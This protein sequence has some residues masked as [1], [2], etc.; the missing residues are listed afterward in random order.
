MNNPYLSA[1]QVR[2]A[3]RRLHL[4]PTRGMG[5]HFLISAGTLRRIV[6]AAALQPGERVIEVGPGLGVLTWELLQR[7]AHVVAVELDK[8]LAAHLRENLLP[9]A[10]AAQQ[11]DTATPPSAP[12]HI[13]QGDV[14]RL[15]PATLLQ[16]A[17]PHHPDHPAHPPDYKVVANLPYAITS[18][19]LRHFLEHTPQPQQMVVLVQWEV[20]QRITAAPGD[21]SMLAHAIQFYAQ[22]EIVGRVAAGSFVPPPAVASAI[23]RLWVRPTPAVQVDDTATFFALIKAGFSQPR[24]KL[25]NALAGGLKAQGQHHIGREQVGAALHAAGVAP[26][27]RAET[28]ALAEWAAIYRALA[29]RS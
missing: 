4:Q 5:Q 29:Q 21:L 8:R 11:H 1:Q 14:L 13:V 27:R 22:P 17:A 12:L 15:P 26:E 20:A 16:Q 7:G 28:V 3:L 19:V 6:E 23:L 25:A 2:A 24:K 10:L 18:P 9:T